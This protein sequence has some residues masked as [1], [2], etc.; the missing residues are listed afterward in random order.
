MTIRG[1]TQR[2]FM[3]PGPDT[4]RTLF[5]DTVSDATFT[6]Y[7]DERLT[8]AEAY[9][10]AS[11]IAHVLIHQYGV[12]QGR[13]SGDLHAKLPRVDAGFQQR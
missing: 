7:E 9:A 8:F 11:K 2:V 13:S 6:V 1:A 5:S 12:D 3:P 4:L 10:A